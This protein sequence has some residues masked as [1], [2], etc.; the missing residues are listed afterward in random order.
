MA[1]NKM[2]EQQHGV[3]DIL[4]TYWNAYGGSKAVF[5]S[6]F[7]W[8]SIALLVLT[9]HYWL[10][11]EW[12]DQVLSVMP[13]VLGFTLG[14]FAI[15]LGFGD[16]EFRKLISGQEPEEDGPS[17]YVEVSSTFLH[18][19]FVQL[20]TLLMAISVKATRF[21]LTE[22][23]FLAGKIWINDLAEILVSARVIADMFGY[24]LFLYGL[25]ITAAAALAIF[26]VSFW[27][28]SLQT[29]NR[30]EEKK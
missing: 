4:K 11:K 3:R 24:W 15:F 1:E 8:I 27:Y 9:T 22:I 17:P 19:V 20:V 18:F 30:Q 21:D 14:G 26:R 16:E 6:P 28:D 13:N 7:F 2:S 12:W 5:R 25:C 29:A 23:D 10:T